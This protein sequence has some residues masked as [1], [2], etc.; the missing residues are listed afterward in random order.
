M[1][2]IKKITIALFLYFVSGYSAYSNNILIN[3]ENDKL[4]RDI[5][6]N[7]F[8]S[9]DFCKAYLIENS[10]Y[11]ING[12]YFSSYEASDVKY[13][14]DN[15]LNCIY[16]LKNEFGE[17]IIESINPLKNNFGYEYV[18]NNKVNDEINILFIY[19]V[20][21]G[22]F[23]NNIFFINEIEKSIFDSKVGNIKFNSLGAFPVNTNSTS[24]EYIINSIK[25]E[26]N[27]FQ[28]VKSIMNKIK[29]DFYVYVSL[30]KE[31]L[32]GNIYRLG[33]ASGVL[34]LNNGLIGNLSNEKDEVN[35]MVTI[36]DKGYDTFLHEFGHLF[37]LMH[38]RE[39]SSTDLLKNAIYPFASGYGKSNDQNGG[40]FR[41]L[42]AYP[43]SFTSAQSFKLYSSPY[44]TC[45]NQPCGK[46]KYL[47][48]DGA[49]AVSALKVTIPQILNFRDRDIN[50]PKVLITTSRDDVVLG[51]DLEDVINLDNGNDIV[52]TSKS[53]TLQNTMGKDLITFGSGNDKLY[54]GSVDDLG[55]TEIQDY[56]Y[57]DLLVF[58]ESSEND[59]DYIKNESDLI[60]ESFRNKNKIIIANFYNDFYGY[61]IYYDLEIGK[62]VLRGIRL[63]NVYNSGQYG[64]EDKKSNYYLVNDNTYLDISGYAYHIFEG[65]NIIYGSRKSDT[66][67][68]RSGRYETIIKD[69]SCYINNDLIYFEN[70]NKNEVYYEKI[71]NSLIIKRK[72]S[73]NG[74]DTVIIDNYFYSECFKIEKIKFADGVEYSLSSIINL[75]EN[76]ETNLAIIAIDDDNTNIDLDLSLNKN[77]KIEYIG[78]N[79]DFEGHLY[80]KNGICNTTVEYEKGEIILDGEVILY[81]NCYLKA[82]N[83]KINKLKTDVIHKGIIDSL[84]DVIYSSNQL[85]KMNL[86]LVNNNNMIL[87]FGSSLNVMESKTKNT[88]LILMEGSYLEHTQKKYIGNINNNNGVFKSCIQGY[89]LTYGKLGSVSKINKMI[90]C[91]SN[92]SND[93]EKLPYLIPDEEDDFINSLE[94]EYFDEET[95]ILPKIKIIDGVCKVKQQLQGYTV[96]V[97]EN[98]YLEK[99]GSLS[100]ENGDCHI[101]AK[102]IIYE[103]NN[104]NGQNIKH[105]EIEA[106]NIIYFGNYFNYYNIIDNTS[107]GS[108][109]SKNKII[110]KGKMKIYNLSVYSGVFENSGNINAQ[111]LNIAT[112]LHNSLNGY[113]YGATI[114]TKNEI[115]DMNGL[116]YGYLKFKALNLNDMVIFNKENVYKNLYGK[117]MQISLEGLGSLLLNSDIEF[118]ELNRSYNMKINENSNGVL[119]LNNYQCNDKYIDYFNGVIIL[120]NLKLGDFKYPKICNFKAKKVIIE[121]IV[122][123]TKDVGK[124]NVEGDIEFLESNQYSYIDLKIT[125]GKLIVNN[126]LTLKY[127]NLINSS[128]VNNGNLILKIINTNNPNYLEGN[129]PNVLKTILS[130]NLV[131]DKNTILINPQISSSSTITINDGVILTLENSLNVYITTLNISLESKGKLILNNYTCKDGVVNYYNGEVEL[132][133]LRSQIDGKYYCKINAK[134]IEIN[135]TDNLKSLY[136]IELDGNLKLKNETI[137]NYKTTLKVKN[138][139]IINNGINKVKSIDLQNGNIINGEGLNT[140]LCLTRIDGIY[141]KYPSNLE[142]CQ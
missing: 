2:F 23:F 120:K 40:A 8:Y 104:E 83:I 100:G 45:N 136:L 27:E 138:G 75:N 69:D 61:D 52:Y 72:D 50:D 114:S 18:I 62:N 129:L 121:S 125:N 73:L 103:K 65:K 101:I 141:Y 56:T 116:N 35:G 78:E 140:Y 14:Q 21:N 108:L 84:S 29:A 6:G 58:Y 77:Y 4:Y 86:K 31:E 134:V 99:G 95:K 43:E 11:L 55:Y 142:V 82:K 30:N 16:K 122:K 111:I 90:N 64:N 118:D 87:N 124:I 13:D 135:S 123:E 139:N 113:I 53:N 112:L 37:G 12:Y 48:T 32:G 102:N 137:N 80:I 97:T 74:Y 128:I 15:N 105:F 22:M 66:Y 81:D 117:Q 10:I 133:N 79:I 71:G 9:L 110:N 106:E 60:I 7:I 47:G 88:N 91:E 89:N 57:D 115:Y 59:F 24:F 34:G 17:E 127:I 28:N 68:F 98:A 44:N 92:L 132:N 94:I 119:T 131:F 41:T 93:L 36:V 3:I 96:F 63:I 109:K 42:M 51:S 1:I 67:I 39:I 54:I 20:K 107:Y 19:D 38:N 126:N 5:N 33:K 70:F 85:L 25:N 49:D 76:N 46:N 130:G 26:T